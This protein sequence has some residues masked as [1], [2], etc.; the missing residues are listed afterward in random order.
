MIAMQRYRA[1]LS[2]Y[3]RQMA[4]FEQPPK[5]QREADPPERPVYERAIV[6]D[7][8]VEALAPL[9]VDNPRGLLLFRDETAG[10]LSGMGQYKSGRGDDQAKW[11]EVHGARALRIDRKTGE[12]RFIFVRAPR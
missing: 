2:R 9:L 6:S 4:E 12:E 8:T 10:W 11:L 3:K 5:K 7:T 1:E